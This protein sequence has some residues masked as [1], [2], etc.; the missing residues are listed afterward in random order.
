MWGASKVT[1]EGVAS[2]PLISAVFLRA[3][4]KKI[5]FLEGL[6]EKGGVS[7][8]V[9]DCAA[10]FYLFFLGS[11]NRVTSFIARPGGVE[12][13]LNGHKYVWFFLPDLSFQK[14]DLEPSI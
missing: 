4:K 1:A 13:K 10:I 8:G 3:S 6:K 14:N 9:E 2:A 7:K 5:R 11:K 12:I